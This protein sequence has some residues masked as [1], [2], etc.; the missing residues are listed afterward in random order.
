MTHTVF[1]PGEGAFPT[2]PAETAAMHDPMITGPASSES[3]LGEDRNILILVAHD[4]E[5]LLSLISVSL[6]RAEHEVVTART[7]EK[8][9]EL[10]FTRRPNLAPTDVQMPCLTG[11][12]V[13]C[14]LRESRET[15]GMPVILVSADAHEQ[16][17]VN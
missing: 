3:E 17:I 14:R 15:H 13:L 4:E 12:D 10:I 5:D 9:L 1:K 16:A 6:L 2:K 8:A 7:G 11:H